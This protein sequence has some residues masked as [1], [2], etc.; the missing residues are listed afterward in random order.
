MH[1]RLAHATLGSNMR[2]RIVL[3]ILA[4]ASLSFVVA[5][6]GSD[7]DDD[8]GD[9][10]PTPTSDAID[11]PQGES[12]GDPAGVP[13][14]DSPT[15]S[16]SSPSV[17]VGSEGDAVVEVVYDLTP[18]I[19]AWTI[20]ITFDTSIVSVAECDAL[21]ATAVCNPEYEDDTV[22][23]VGASLGIE[24]EAVLGRI[25]FLC[26]QAG[27]SALEISVETLAD[28]T[29]GDPQLLAPHL[30]DGTITCS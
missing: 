5:C 22:R 12:S 29:I 28:G 20:D 18:G 10:G 19:G 30:E 21:L 26:D 27:E 8:K 15:V 4:L 2:I 6:G 14:P 9:N 16:I 17:D 25:T 11:E 13:G 3:A 24:S 23:I 1:E 7:D